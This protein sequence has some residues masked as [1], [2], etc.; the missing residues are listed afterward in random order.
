MKHLK[1]NRDSEI[2]EI[3]LSLEGSIRS[4]MIEMDYI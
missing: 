3:T 2:G 4:L 1:H